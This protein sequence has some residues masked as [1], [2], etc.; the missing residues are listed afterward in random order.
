[1]V[2]MVFNCCRTHGWTYRNVELFSKIASRQNI[3][4]EEV[5]GLEACVVTEH[6]L[7]HVDDNRARN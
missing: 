3:L 6:N 1:M 4:V 2:T 5:F 7:I